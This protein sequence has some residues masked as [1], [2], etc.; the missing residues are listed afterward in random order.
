MD[1]KPATEPLPISHIRAAVAELT[2]AIN[3]CGH[4]R[5]RRQLLGQA[6]DFCNAALRTFDRE[7]K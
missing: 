3:A 7:A 4:S 1:G 5:Q 6:R 2:I